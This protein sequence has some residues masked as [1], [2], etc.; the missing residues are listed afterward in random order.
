MIKT[1]AGYDSHTFDAIDTLLHVATSCNASFILVYRSDDNKQ[2]IAK[3]EYYT[4]ASCCLLLCVP[5]GVRVYTQ[6]AMY[7]LLYSVLTAVCCTSGVFCFACIF[8]F[9]FFSF[10]NNTSFLV[11]YTPH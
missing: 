1:G 10:D 4:A 7:V 3:Q 8:H 5:A 11:V 2:I 6:K 9:S